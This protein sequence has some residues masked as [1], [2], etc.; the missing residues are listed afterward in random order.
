ML[1]SFFG[2][3]KSINYILLAAALPLVLGLRFWVTFSGLPSFMQVLELIGQSGL[4]IFSLLLL[5]FVIRKNKLTQP[6][7]YGLWW[8]FCGIVAAVEPGNLLQALVLTLSLLSLRRM[9][10]LANEQNLEKKIFDAALW[11]FMV[12]MFY[13]WFLWMILALYM[14]VAQLNQIAW[15]YYFIPLFSALCLGLIL[16]G[17]M[18]VFPE[19]T[20]AVPGGDTLVNL[21]LEP[22]NWSWPKPIWLQLGLAA[23]ALLL[24]T[25]LVR[26]PLAYKEGTTMRQGHFQWVWRVLIMVLV[27]AGFSLDQ[28]TEVF[29][30][31][32]LPLTSILYA[33]SLELKQPSWMREF[34]AFLPLVMPLAQLLLK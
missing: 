21:E 10:S 20:A 23:G 2:N 15:R 34:L 25:T 27:L 14:A 28:K 32:V 19:I 11:I 16:A 7:T 31:L 24:V 22:L 12:S 26:L 30:W 29:I 13:P 4:L 33:N 6:N 17:A 1:T 8:F 9:M 3:S 5:D 18:A